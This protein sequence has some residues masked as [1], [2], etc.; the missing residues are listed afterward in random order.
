MK[1]CLIVILLINLISKQIYSK[2]NFVSFNTYTQDKNK[3]IFDI[4]NLTIENNESE[5]IIINIRKS[6]LPFSQIIDL[7]VI[8]YKKNDKYEFSAKDGFGNNIYGYMKYINK[9]LIEFY[10]D[11]ESFSEDG[12]NLARLYGDLYYLIKTD[13]LID[14]EEIYSSISTTLK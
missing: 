2:E 5:K 6:L 3:K 14:E 12:K 1:K 11:C 4:V 13:D 8:A 9:N 7:N 10:I